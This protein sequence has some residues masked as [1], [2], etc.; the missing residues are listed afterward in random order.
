[1][2]AALGDTLVYEAKEG[3]RKPNKG[4]GEHE[5]ER[6]DRGKKGFMNSV[7]RKKPVEGSLH[8]KHGP[9]Y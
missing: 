4:N 6:D 8:T 1:M 5:K 3:K 7:H 2:W 9:R